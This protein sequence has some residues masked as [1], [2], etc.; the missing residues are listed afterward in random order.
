MWEEIIEANETD[1]MEIHLI[2]RGS[3]SDFDQNE[4]QGMRKKIKSE[5]DNIIEII[6][7][8]Q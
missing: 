1:K 7:H 3:T 4:I 6:Y 5:R 2:P 8:W